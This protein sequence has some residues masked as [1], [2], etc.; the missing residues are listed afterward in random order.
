[1]N[2]EHI[3]QNRYIEIIWKKK[4]KYLG[5]LQ[6]TFVNDMELIEKS[7]GHDSQL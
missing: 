7:Q 6:S 3:K 2:K 4:R 5:K 1:M